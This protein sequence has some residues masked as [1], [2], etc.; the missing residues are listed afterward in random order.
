[1]SS[2]GVKKSKKC[3]RSAI[4]E[5]LT[6]QEHFQDSRCPA[7]DLVFDTC[8]HPLF[9]PPL[10][11]RIPK[12]HKI[13]LSYNRHFLYKLITSVRLAGMFS[14]VRPSAIQKENIV[15]IDAIAPG[16]HRSEIGRAGN[17]EAQDRETDKFLDDYCAVWIP[18]GRCQD[19][20]KTDRE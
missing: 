8:G 13:L 4:N 15:E 9:S 11:L 12:D 17:P 1:V 5:Q 14:I 10:C 19:G 6:T 18:K 2:N 20:G 3:T 16:M 7:N